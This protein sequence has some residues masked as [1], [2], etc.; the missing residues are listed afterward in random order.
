M[1]AIGVP[2]V[3]VFVNNNGAAAQDQQRMKA[4]LARI[5]ERAL[6]FGDKG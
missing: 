2:A 5:F 3:A 6:K 4:V 1:R